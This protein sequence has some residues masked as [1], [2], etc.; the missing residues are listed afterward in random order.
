MPISAVLAT[1]VPPQS[2]RETSSTS[3][4]RTQS[5]YF[6][7]NSAIAPSASASARSISSART[8]L[9]ALTQSLT[10]SSIAR[11][12]SRL[13]GAPWVKSKR[14]LSGRTAEPACRT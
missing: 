10:R 1:W 11:T 14:S 9:L 13:S 8:G 5:P 7:P 3:I 12:S 4:T 2:S 6:S